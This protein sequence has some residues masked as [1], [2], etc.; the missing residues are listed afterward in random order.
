MCVSVMQPGTGAVDRPIDDVAFLARSQNRVRV[1]EELREAPLTRGELRDRTDISRPTIGRILEGLQERGW[2]TEDQR[3]YSLTPF[4]RLV[5]SEFEALIEVTDTVQTLRDLEASLPLAEMDFDLRR[6]TE[7]TVTTPTSTDAS[8]HFRRE[9][10]LMDRTT[11]ARFLCTESHGPT[12]EGYLERVREQD[13][14]LEVVIAAD[15]IDAATADDRLR[16]LVMDLVAAERTT[17][18]RYEGPVEVMLGTLDDVATIVPL[19]DTGVPAAFIEARDPAVREWITATL[20]EHRAA[21]TEITLESL[22]P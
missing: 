2:V 22:E 4:G 14:E 19:D 3:T 21:A 16:P 20:D 6:L 13:L 10:E 17:F 8:A 1:M 11:H 18:Y 5:G 15:A 12:I 7:A 9:E